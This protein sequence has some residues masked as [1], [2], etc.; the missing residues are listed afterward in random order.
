MK[1]DIV[2]AKR[3]GWLKEVPGGWQ[4][5]EKRALKVPSGNLKESCDL[6]LCQGTTSVVPN[7]ACNGERL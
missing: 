1:D 3:A 5:E 7:A 4:A 6:A 2:F